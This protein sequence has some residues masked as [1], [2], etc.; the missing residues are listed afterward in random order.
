MNDTILEVTELVD[1]ISP[2]EPGTTGNLFVLEYKCGFEP[3]GL[4][5]ETWE[6]YWVLRLPQIPAF[7][8]STNGWVRFMNGLEMEFKGE[9]MRDVAIQAVDF[10][11]WY[12]ENVHGKEK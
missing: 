11:R 9:R 1:R 10:L 5:S 2:A 6:N 4:A 7:W 3:N 8:K 12:L